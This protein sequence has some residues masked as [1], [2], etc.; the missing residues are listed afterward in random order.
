MKISDS[1]AWYRFSMHT[2]A[3]KEYNLVTIA[4]RI[5]KLAYYE[6]NRPS[7]KNKKCVPLRIMKTCIRKKM[8]HTT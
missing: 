5:F 7:N 4:I 6:V 3:T 2:F 8:G 1:G